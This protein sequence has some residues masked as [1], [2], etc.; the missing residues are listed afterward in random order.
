MAAPPKI[1]KNFAK[2]FGDLLKDFGK[3]QRQIA[4]ECG[5]SASVINRLCKDGTGSE[6]HICIV[7]QKFDIKRRRIVEILTD[8]RAELS[9]EPAKTV[10]QNFR[11][12]FVDEDEYLRDI[13]PFPLERAYACTQFGI[14]IL[15]VVQLALKCGISKITDASDI[16][17]NK[18]MRFMS[19][20]EEQ[21]GRE[22]RKAVFSPRCGAYPPALLLDFK[23]QI[24]ASDHVE[25]IHCRGQLLFGLPH[26]IVGNYTFTEHGEITRHRNTGGIEFLYSLEGDFELTC[27][28]TTYSTTLKPGQMIFV[29]DARKSH[30][31]KLIGGKPGRLL[32][33][34]YYPQ[35]KELTP[36]KK[37]N[38]KQ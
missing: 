1:A 23:H 33:I 12:A 13:C 36:G 37:R 24:D 16:N 26:L 32:M 35:K 4:D 21:F 30:K 18:L 14:H 20:F 11:Y 28:Q 2:K 5:I 9:D 34:R 3:T 19:E 10:W 38:P 17:A 8:R 31:I 27:G 22:A 15:D 25:L 29:L 7:L 6:S